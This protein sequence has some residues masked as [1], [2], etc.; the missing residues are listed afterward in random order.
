MAD[1]GREV[2]IP[3]TPT[4]DLKT[5]VLFENLPMQ[6]NLSMPG[7]P[8]DTIGRATA[9][10]KEDGSSTIEI[11]LDAEATKR[12]TDL[13]SVFELWSIG[14]AGIKRRPYESSSE[15]PKPTTPDP[16]KEY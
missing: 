10:R 14:F 8:R 1:E 15:L 13:Q 9:I 11:K 3:E 5:N 7:D 2:H 16:G 12:L 4:D 6:V